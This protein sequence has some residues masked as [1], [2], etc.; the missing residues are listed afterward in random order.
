MQVGEKQI[1][2]ELLSAFQFFFAVISFCLFYTSLM[3][4]YFVVRR[5]F[6]FK[7]ACVVGARGVDLI[8]SF[9]DF[10]CFLRYNFTPMLY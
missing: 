3:A 2:P 6:F 10:F 4:S 9:F 7:C 5:Q 1:E 8:T